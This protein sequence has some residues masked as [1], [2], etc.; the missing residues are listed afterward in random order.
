[1]SESYKLQSISAL[2]KRNE[3]YDINRAEI[4]GIFS[5][6]STNDSIQNFTD[7]PLH[8]AHNSSE[9]STPEQQ[10]FWNR[11]RNIFSSEQTV[12]KNDYKDFSD[13]FFDEKTGKL[14]PRGREILD[15]LKGNVRVNEIVAHSWGSLILNNAI[16]EGV[17]PPPRRIV[18]VGCPDADLTRW[19]LLARMT[20]TEVVVFTNTADVVAG[21]PKALDN[22]KKFP[23]AS[24][25][26]ERLY[27]EGLIDQDW[28]QW[29]NAHPDPKRVH[30]QFLPL[31]ANIGVLADGGHSRIN[32]YQY[33]LQQG[34]LVDLPTMQ[35]SQD[36]KV[37]SLAGEL[38][39]SDI[40]K[41]VRTIKAERKRQRAEMGQLR[42]NSLR[43]SLR[44][45]AAKLCANSNSVSQADIDR[46]P[47]PA[48][49]QTFESA[50]DSSS[51][52]DSCEDS[53]YVLLRHETASGKINLGFVRSLAHPDPA[54]AITAEAA[55]AVDPS[56]SV[57]VARAAQASPGEDQVRACIGELHAIVHEICSSGAA[58]DGQSRRFSDCWRTLKVAGPLYGLPPS[59]AARG[60]SACD[61]RLM[62]TIP[63][64]CNPFGSDPGTY[65]CMTHVALEAY[66]QAQYIAQ[67]ISRLSNPPPPPP[68]QPPCSR[69][70]NTDIGSFPHPCR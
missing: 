4:T 29:G 28:R 70:V 16:L 9:P 49:P 60:L 66:A 67:D 51:L 15:P 7:L 68:Q 1:M 45:L 65:R 5:T 17:I 11:L 35:K 63:N 61:G 47:H 46:L 43:A 12:V 10:G 48:N 44:R 22:L 52:G 39:E 54:L 19:S 69:D 2:R 18:V 36:D 25:V 58:N 64:W 6:D 14:S 57:A 55:Q 8:P 40:Q 59:A 50:E 23:G 31:Y 37:A 3:Y 26:F 30:G 13:L 20:G 62:A 41:L 21:L 56:A 42:D 53:V 32:Y 24:A 33:L 38:E 27:D 34:K